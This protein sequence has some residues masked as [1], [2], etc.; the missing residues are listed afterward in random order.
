[1]ISVDLGIAVFIAFD[2]AIDGQVHRLKHPVAFTSQAG[3]YFRGLILVVEQIDAFTD[4]RHRGFEQSSVDGDTAIFG[5]CAAHND[6]KMIFQILWRPPQT[7][8]VGPIALQG[9]IAG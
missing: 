1:M 4:Q 6:T 3:L 8:D 7:L 5:D 9:V 2:T